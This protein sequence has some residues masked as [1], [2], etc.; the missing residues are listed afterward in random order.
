MNQE[1]ISIKTPK[2]HY[3]AGVVEAAG[4]RSNII[5][6]GAQVFT[7]IF[8]GC[9]CHGFRQGQGNRQSQPQEFDDNFGMEA[10]IGI[11]RGMLQ[12]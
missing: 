11:L 2:P 7:D 5:R 12:E 3:L 4:K 1:R 8:R 9:G 10:S 6:W